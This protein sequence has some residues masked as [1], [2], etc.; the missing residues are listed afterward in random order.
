MEGKEILKMGDFYASG[1]LISSIVH[2]NLY[3]L[4]QIVHD[5]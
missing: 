4:K 3:I 1:K 5:N 2:L